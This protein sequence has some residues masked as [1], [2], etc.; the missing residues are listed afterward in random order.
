M[1]KENLHG[2]QGRIVA[3]ILAGGSGTRAGGEVP[4]QFWQVAGRSVL[5]HAVAAFERNARV[6]EIVIVS[7][8]ADLPA[9]EALVS[10]VGWHKV[11]RVV[12]GGRERYDSSLAAIRLYD[13]PTIRL[14]LHDAARPLVSQQIIDAV[15]DALASH[16]AVAVALPVTDT[17]F[18]VRE[19]SVEE[20]VERSSLARAQTPQAFTLATIRAAYD[21]ALADPLFRATDDCGV[22]M[23]YLPGT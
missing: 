12:A 13:D 3:A 15:I 6:D 17:I 10:R 9:V 18:R 16:D 14:L 22:L 1:G 20:I 4:K 21:K 2:K 11:T 7:R 5:E 8:P 19:G 23:R